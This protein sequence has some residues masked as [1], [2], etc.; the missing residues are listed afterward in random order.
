MEC[1]RLLNELTN[2]EREEADKKNAE[3]ERRRQINRESS[4][5]GRNLLTAINVEGEVTDVKCM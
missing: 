5:R 4:K 3:S 1:C 2:G